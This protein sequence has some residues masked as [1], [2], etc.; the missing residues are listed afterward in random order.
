MIRDAQDNDL[1]TV[2]ALNAESE[3]FLSPMD[4]SRLARL[5][6]QAAYHRVHSPNYRWFAERDSYFLYIDRVVVSARHRGKLTCEFDLYG[7]K[8][9]SLQKAT[10][11]SA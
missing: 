4:A 6:A 9:V 10:P 8:R 11:C 2:V 7:N 1:A 5:H 3:R